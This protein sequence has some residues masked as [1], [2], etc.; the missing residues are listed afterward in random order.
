MLSQN[1]IRLAAQSIIQD[2][3]EGHWIDAFVSAERLVEMLRPHADEMEQQYF[4]D[5][6]NEKVEP[7]SGRKVQ[8]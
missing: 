5:F 3:R 7:Q 2:I 6:R 8:R 4:E 1:S